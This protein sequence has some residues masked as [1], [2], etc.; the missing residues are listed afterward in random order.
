MTEVLSWKQAK[1]FVRAHSRVLPESIR[2]YRP[3]SYVEII[4]TDPDTVNPKT[5]RPL[6]YMASAVATLNNR[7]KWN[8]KLGIEIATGKAV[9]VL[10]RRLRAWMIRQR[11]KEQT[12]ERHVVEISIPLEETRVTIVGV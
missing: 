6:S 11:R 12:P 3:H 5:G 9:A 8:A 4:F 10:A 7:D 2:Q 1:E